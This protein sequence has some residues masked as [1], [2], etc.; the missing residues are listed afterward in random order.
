MVDER[1]DLLLLGLRVSENRLHFLATPPGV[2]GRSRLS[3][4]DVG[5]DDDRWHT[6]VLA[7]SGPYA[8][9]TVDCGLPLE[10]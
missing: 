8:T 6:V 4:K 5:L 9:L 2:G 3:F 10:L 7:I 1:S